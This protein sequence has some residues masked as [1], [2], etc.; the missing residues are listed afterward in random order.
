MSLNSAA[1][2]ICC[3]DGIMGV[4]LYDINKAENELKELEDNHYQ[5]Y[6]TQ[7]KNIKAYKDLFYWHIHTVDVY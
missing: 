3:N 7:Y 4:V 6:K 5:K 1:H 2:V